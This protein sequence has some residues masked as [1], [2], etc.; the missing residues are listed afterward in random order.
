MKPIINACRKSIS[1]LSSGLPDVG[2]SV[3]EVLQPV[4]AT[5]IQKQQIAG[6]TQEILIEIN[7][8]VSIQSM[9]PAT[10]KMMPE[11]QRGW[12]YNTVFALS[13]L[14]LKLDEVFTIKGKN[15]RILGKTDWK[16]FGFI[17]YNT[18]ED[19]QMSKPDTTEGTGY[20][21]S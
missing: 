15:Y 8:K 11:G 13:N 12:D 16:E 10:L 17:E 21:T 6:Y 3:M 2:A 20:V 7:T 18:V 19:Y 5:Y 14:N 1:E 4:V 9:S